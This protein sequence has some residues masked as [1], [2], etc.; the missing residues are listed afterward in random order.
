VDTFVLLGTSHAAMRR[1]FAVCEKVFE[2]P[3]GALPP[4]RHFIA[5]LEEG[6]CFDVREEEHLHKQEHSLELQILFLQHILGGRRAGIVPVLC[7]L[8]HRRARAL[9]P[10]GDAAAASF[11]GALRGALERRG[12]RALVI[13]GADLAHIGPRF[14]DPVPLDEPGRVAL[15]LRDRGSI[16]RALD[17]DAPGF[18]ADVFSDLDVRRV[19][20]LAPIH[21]LL[22]A[23]PAAA[24]GELLGYAQCVDPEEGSIVSHASIAFYTDA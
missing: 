21:A 2:T 8:P 10:P 16:D 20:G 4:D 7:G 1:P 18:F 9:E 12:D 5:E 11:L 24:R 14:G 13:T 3:L 17:L 6:S 19:C 23:V 15:G 22:R